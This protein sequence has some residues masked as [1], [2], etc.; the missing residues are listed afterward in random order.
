MIIAELCVPLLLCP[1]I[2][3]HLVT[4]LCLLALLGL[5][6]KVQLI[7]VVVTPFSDVLATDCP[8]ALDILPP[9]SAYVLLKTEGK[10]G[11]I[12]S[13]FV[14]SCE[15]GIPL[16]LLQC[17]ERLCPTKQPSLTIK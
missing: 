14:D 11:E 17:W 10:I 12:V 2:F 6:T 16:T 15:P 8:R 5:H 1:A 13:N 4:F 7:V 3:F 9:N